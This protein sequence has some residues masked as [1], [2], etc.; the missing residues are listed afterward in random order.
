MVSVSE[1]EKRKKQIKILP[2]KVKSGYLYRYSKMVRSAS[3]GAVF[4]E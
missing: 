3:S 4:K 1:I 2:S